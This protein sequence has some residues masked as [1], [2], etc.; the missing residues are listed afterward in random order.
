MG[1]SLSRGHSTIKQSN[2]HINKREKNSIKMNTLKVTI[3]A[4]ALATAYARPQNFDNFDIVNLLKDVNLDDNAGAVIAD[5]VVQNVEDD[6]YYDD[7]PAYA[8]TYQVADDEEQTYIK[9]S[10]ERDGPK[11]T[12]EYSYVDP[13]GGL[14]TVSY[15]AD[16]NGFQE[17]REYIPNFL[18]QNG[19]PI[20]ATTTPKPTTPRPRP[21]QPPKRP[22][23]DLIAK[24]IAQLTPHIQNTVSNSINQ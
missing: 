20:V 10:E 1:I 19:P 5:A 24:I 23:E 15:L 8:Y 17:T 6:P 22:N 3:F 9:Q 21:T 7:N 14:V 12:G 13:L 16:E 11:V 4:L 2:Q 18:A